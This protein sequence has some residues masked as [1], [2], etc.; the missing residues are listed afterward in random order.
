MMPILTIIDL[1]TLCD[2]TNNQRTD[3]SSPVCV[4]RKPYLSSHSLGEM[5]SK[6]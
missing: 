6:G 1:N 5:M 4:C 2:L 3:L